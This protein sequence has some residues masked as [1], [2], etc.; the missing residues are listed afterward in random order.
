M[1]RRLQFAAAMKASK[2]I[3]FLGGVLG[4]IAFFLPLITV[5][6]HGQKIQPSA[7]Q[8]F[9][10]VDAIGHEV[11]TN[12]ELRASMTAG[13]VSAT[14]DGASAVKGIVIAVFLPA[15]MLALL[16]GI[17]VAR[18]RFQ[19]VAGTFSLVFGVIGLAI[20]GLL[21]AAAEGDSGAGIMLLLATGALG[22]VGGLLALIK[23][24]RGLQTA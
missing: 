5:T 17:G 22:F 14:K 2:F 18:R 4:I 23:P 10:G 16:G 19:R 8:I 21:V 1:A 7:M 13:S 20:A 15:I 3:V 11:D 9:K 24:D 6:T 12:K